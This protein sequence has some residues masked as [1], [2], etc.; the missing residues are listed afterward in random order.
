MNRLPLFVAGYAFHMVVVVTGATSGIGRAIARRFAQ[1][2]AAVALL[3]RGRDGL[4]G[5]RRDVEQAGGRALVLPT[6]VADWDA[7]NSAA[8][9][10]EEA[11]GPI[12]VWVNNAMT[13][14]FAP[15][16]E[17][18]P[19]EFRR[20]TE[21]TY[22]GAVWGTKAA[23]DR[24]L[25]RDRG[26]I[27]LVGSALAYRG[28]PLQAPYCGAKHAEKG[29]FESLRTELRHDK[30][31]VHLSMVQLPGHNTPQFVHCRSKMPKVP[32][33]MPPHYQPEVAAEAVHW[34]AHNRR[35]ELYVGF[36]TLKTIVGNKVAPWLVERV[37]AKQGVSGQQS[38]KPADPDRPDNLESPP[39]GDPGAHGPY[40]EKARTSAVLTELSKRRRVAGVVTGAA[41]L[42]AG[43]VGGRR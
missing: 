28:I 8:R 32:Q 40:D 35:R 10:V 34:A 33:P 20:A 3:A 17:I 18:E 13:T 42:I 29:F 2:G 12:D 38:D 36:P 19:D 39:P 21:V 27:V 31:N 1:D 7:V 26:S 4:E 22:L 6:D 16:K 25:P 24:M 30:S 41:L 43:V 14:V 37:L 5:A 9:A 15:F 23:L 11:F